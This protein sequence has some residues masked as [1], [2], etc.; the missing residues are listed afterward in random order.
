[1]S[2]QRGLAEGLTLAVLA[3]AVSA[4][5]LS[6]D[7]AWVA[8][9]D[10]PDSL[11]D[12][13]TALALTPDG[14]LV[15]V[16]VTVEQTPSLQEPRLLVLR[17]DAHGGLLWE[18]RIASPLPG[19]PSVD[20]HAV[21][22]DAAGRITAAGT[23]RPFQAVMVVQLDPDGQTRWLE[24]FTDPEGAFVDAEDVAV[25]AA[26]NVYATADA[27]GSATAEPA[28]TV[29]YDL[30]GVASPLIS[31]SGP[32]GGSFPRANGVSADGELVVAGS[33]LYEGVGGQFAVALFDVN[34][35]FVWEYQT[36]GDGAATNDLA[37]DVVT[38]GT[39][40]VATGYVNGN[41]AQGQDV[42]TVRLDRAGQVVWAD[43]YTTAP[44][45][46]DTGN[47][48][49]VDGSGNVFVAG[50]AEMG[51]GEYDALV[52]KYDEQGTLLWDRHYSGSASGVETA[53][54]VAPDGEGGA[55]VAGSIL[56]APGVSAFFVVHYDADGVLVGE[57]IYPGPLGGGSRAADV[58]ADATG[59]A[60]ATGRSPGDG[61]D[62]D[63]ATLKISRTLFA[64]GF[65]SGDL[66]RWSV[67]VQ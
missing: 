4:A 17:Y 48:V 9:Y 44:E 29:R 41:T 3:L 15:V 61:T 11:A 66:S 65:E 27:Y 2:R 20:G 63:V 34:G 7:P 24:T 23:V 47:R 42:W 49:A 45:G 8:R 26:A 59:A 52:L 55:W 1:M 43:Q 53:R 36:G 25:D 30:D 37:H 64:D 6:A 60:Y 56:I 39:D 28:A 57:E 16:G 32:E 46:T 10:G 18:R 50:S 13:G 67:S 35:E 62:Y 40:V 12:E 54:A 31:Y 14:H 38:V 19:F 21:A 5:P 51:F 58:V 33:T 22:V